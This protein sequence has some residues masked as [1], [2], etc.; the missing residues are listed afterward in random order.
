MDLE[1]GGTELRKRGEGRGHH[2][3]DDAGSQSIG[4]V[5][6]PLGGCVLGGIKACCGF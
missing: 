4:L 6:C 5:R 1:A 2:G 3:R